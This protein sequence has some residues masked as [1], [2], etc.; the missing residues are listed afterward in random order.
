M[1]NF[2][3]ALDLRGDVAAG[4]TIPQK[5]AVGRQHRLAADRDVARLA[6]RQGH[7]VSEFAK[8]PVGR[9]IGEMLAPA[10]RLQGRVG[11]LFAVLADHVGR[12]GAQRM[13]QAFR[14]VGEAQ[15]RSHLPEPVGARLGESLE[16]LLAGDLLHFGKL[17]APCCVPHRALLMALRH[18]DQAERDGGRQDLRQEK[19]VRCEPRHVAQER[20]VENMQAP[21]HEAHADDAVLHARARRARAGTP[22]R[23]RSWRC[24]ARDRSAASAAR[25]EVRTRRPR[26]PSRPASRPRPPGPRA[27]SRA[28]N[29]GTTRPAAGP[30]SRPPRPPAG[31]RPRRHPVWAPAASDSS[32]AC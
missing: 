31:R 3:F 32:A 8:R 19:P 24:R 14:H 30:C 26:R 18:D 9:Q 5:F 12:V 1:L 7:L 16:A 13:A 27:G 17:G 6:V 22:R 25:A 23:W 15:I 11:Q 29:R 10:L 28:R 2:L 21:E 4:A 20:K